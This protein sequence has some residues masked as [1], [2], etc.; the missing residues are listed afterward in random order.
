[1]RWFWVKFYF[2]GD[3]YYDDTSWHLVAATDPE[4]IV[5]DFERTA[6]EVKDILPIEYAPIPA[7]PRT[8]KHAR[9]FNPELKQP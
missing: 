4:Q 7:K 6:Y 2:S 9:I 8:T 3:G 1:M 5:R